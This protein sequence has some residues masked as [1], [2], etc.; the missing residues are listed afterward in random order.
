ML[1]HGRPDR[2]EYDV[3]GK[4]QEIGVAVDQDRFVPALEEMAA[5]FMATV[6]PLSE[7]P[8]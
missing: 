1:Y 4:L 6:G 3:A 7:D 8:V 5:A 2:I